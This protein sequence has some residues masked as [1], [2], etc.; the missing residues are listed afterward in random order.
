MEKQNARYLYQLSASK[1]YLE[2]CAMEMRAI[3]HD[4]I[5]KNYHLSN[6]LVMQD[7]SPFI[8]ARIDIL[9]TSNSFPD[10]HKQILHDHLL[11][12][13]YKI[14][15]IKF[16]D[17][18]YQDRL[19][20]MRTIGFAITGDYAMREPKVQFALTKLNNSWIFGLYHKSKQSHIYRKHKPH[21]YSNAL[22]TTL[23]KALINIAINNDCSTTIIDPCAGVGTVVI[24]GRF[25]GADIKGYE[26]SPLVKINANKNLEH[27][28]FS[29]DIEK[30]DMLTTKKHFDVAILDLPYG[31]FSFISE[32]EQIQILKHTKAIAS[33]VVLVTMNN[34]ND[35]LIDLDYKVIDQ[36]Q[37][38]K[39]NSFSRYV[40]ILLPN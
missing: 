14:H 17:I 9:Y 8:K 40:S 10:L 13:K 22:E 21:Q 1:S 30:V 34:M 24:E 18:P 6:Q 27:F 7:R 37:I 20:H 15:Y 3:F 35:L 36:C 39:S 2:L 5:K 4:E 25:L 26:L 38:K 12:D 29:A 11:Y 23:A 33:K 16:D 31:Q 19:K 32:E 28:G